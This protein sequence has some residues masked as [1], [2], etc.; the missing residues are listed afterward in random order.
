MEARLLVDNSCA[1]KCIVGRESGLLLVHDN[2]NLTTNTTTADNL[3]VGALINNEYNSNY[4][5]PCSHRIQ[6][7]LSKWTSQASTIELCQSPTILEQNH[8]Q[9]VHCLR[10]CRDEQLV[11][12]NRGAINSVKF[13]RHLGNSPV[14]L[15]LFAPK[16]SRLNSLHRP[17]GSFPKKLLFPNATNFKLGLFFPKSRGTFPV[18]LFVKTLNTS[19][20]RSME[21][22]TGNSPDS[23]LV[24]TAK[25]VR[26]SRFPISGAIVP[27][28][29][30]L[31]RTTKMSF[32]KFPISE[33]IKPVKLFSKTNN[34]SKLLSLEMLTGSSPDSWLVK[35]GMLE[36]LDQSEF[37]KEFAP[38][39][40]YHTFGRWRLM[41]LLLSH[42]SREDDSIAKLFFHVMRASACV[43]GE[44]VIFNGSKESTKI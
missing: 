8:S 36:N 22:L 13:L 31:E 33:G 11:E 43:V 28:K 17:C 27:S 7:H 44:E 35:E 42:E 25:C 24:S 40:K 5:G 9:V 32:V 39:D 34:S 20:L 23:W 15:L 16:Y 37:A 30:F 14:N 29:L 38:R 26:N 1:T 21:I 2:A 6:L 12:N 41:M 10:I 19:K 4:L 18:K 3:P